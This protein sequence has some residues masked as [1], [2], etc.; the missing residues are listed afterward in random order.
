M[1]ARDMPKSFK[2]R[3]GVPRSVGYVNMLVVHRG[4]V[5]R[6]TQAASGPRGQRCA[7]D[8]E[9]GRP[10]EKVRA[11]KDCGGHPSKCLC[12]GCQLIADTVDAGASRIITRSV[13]SRSESWS[14]IPFASNSIRISGVR[15]PG[16]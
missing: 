12:H 13:R 2:D 9:A 5:G 6:K 8:P 14:I 3:G 4:R 15:L 10:R 7:R 1:D 11:D 16:T